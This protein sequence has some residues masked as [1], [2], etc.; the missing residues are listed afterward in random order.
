MRAAA[1]HLCFIDSGH[2][3]F[4][5]CQ[6]CVDP[7]RSTC[8][9]RA[10]VDLHRPGAEEPLSLGRLAGGLVRPKK[11]PLLSQTGLRYVERQ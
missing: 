4:N 9:M 2:L 7:S 11:E 6:V 3:S 10:P 5:S 1:V 8:D